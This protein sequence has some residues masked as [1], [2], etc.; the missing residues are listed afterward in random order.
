MNDE[1]T[2]N[3]DI[4][5]SFSLYHQNQKKKIYKIGGPSSIEVWRNTTTRI[6]Q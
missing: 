1:S 2:K 5:I 3:N 4:F 6:K